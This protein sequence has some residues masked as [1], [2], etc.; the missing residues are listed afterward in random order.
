MTDAATPEEAEAEIARTREE[1][2]ETIDALAARADLKAQ[3]RRKWQDLR[4]QIVDK[5][6]S[7]KGTAGSHTTA[8]TD[9]KAAVGRIGEQV[10]EWARTNPAAALAT[11]VGLGLLL[12]RATKRPRS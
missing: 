5:V 11:A 7:V 1:L 10:I 4:L 6:A 8:A 3:A 12:G 2:G 9:P